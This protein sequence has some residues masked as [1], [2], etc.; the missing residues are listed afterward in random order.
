MMEEPLIRDTKELPK[1]MLRGKK[2]EFLLVL[3][4]PWHKN[5]SYKEKTKQVRAMP[6]FPKENKLK[7]K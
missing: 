5:F 3:Y 7:T 6:I 1:G 4:S 2:Q